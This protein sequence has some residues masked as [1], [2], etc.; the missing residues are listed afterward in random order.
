[1]NITYI[2][3]KKSHMKKVIEL[4]KKNISNYAPK[5]KN[6][7]HIWKLFSTKSNAYSIVAITKKKYYRLWDN[8]FA[9]QN[10]RRRNRSYRGYCCM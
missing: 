1:M 3:F 6:Y 4:L 7:N 5:L 2:I 9:I 8:F 10:K